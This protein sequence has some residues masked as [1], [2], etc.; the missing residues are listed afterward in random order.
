MTGK[1]SVLAASWAVAA[2]LGACTTKTEVVV[3]QPARR[4][5]VARAPAHYSNVRVTHVQTKK[6]GHPKPSPWAT[7]VVNQYD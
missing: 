4:A 7:S 1:L 3:L 5:T 6:T 2:G